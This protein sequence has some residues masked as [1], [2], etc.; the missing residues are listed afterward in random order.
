[1]IKAHTILQCS[2]FWWFFVHLYYNRHENVTTVGKNTSKRLFTQSSMNRC[3]FLGMVGDHIRSSIIF[4]C[5][6]SRIEKREGK[7]VQQQINTKKINVWVYRFYHTQIKK[8]KKAFG[9][10]ST[11]S[12]IKNNIGSS[13]FRNIR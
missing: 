11:S 13:E 8:K 12:P 2:E 10:H 3:L 9:K 1:M 5:A 7:K 4:K 6:C